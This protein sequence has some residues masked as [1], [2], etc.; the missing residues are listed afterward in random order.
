MDIIQTQPY[1][2]IKFS[3]RANLSG[4]PA[5]KP[6]VLMPST[7]NLNEKIGMEQTWHSVNYFEPFKNALICDKSSYGR[8]CF[9]QNCLRFKISFNKVLVFSRAAF[10][11]REAY[12]IARWYCGDQ[13]DSPGALR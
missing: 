2:A 8:C 3:L 4:A 13:I 10:I 9:I 11:L 7:E 12:R 5:R 1:S 6:H